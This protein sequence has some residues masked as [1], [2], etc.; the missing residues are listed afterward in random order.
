MCKRPGA[1]FTRT[2]ISQGTIFQ[3]KSEVVCDAPGEREPCGSDSQTADHYHCARFRQRYTVIGLTAENRICRCCFCTSEGITTFE[4]SDRILWLPSWIKPS[5]QLLSTSEQLLR[6]TASA[7]VPLW[8]TM[9]LIQ[10][11]DRLT[12]MRTEYEVYW[13]PDAS[14]FGMWETRI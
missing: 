5:I 14:N 9:Y 3:V 13:I 1:T 2:S 7:K 12:V 11:I 4:D 8:L 10:E 6:L